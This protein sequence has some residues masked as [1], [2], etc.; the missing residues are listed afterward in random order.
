MLAVPWL[1][2]FAALF[3]SAQYQYRK[4]IRDDA[5]EQG[6]ETVITAVLS[7]MKC[8]TAAANLVWS[9]SFSVAC[10]I[11]LHCFWTIV[12]PAYRAF[13]AAY[14]RARWLTTWTCVCLSVHWVFLLAASFVELPSR[15][16]SELGSTDIFRTKHEWMN[17]DID[18]PI[19][20]D[21]NCTYMERRIRDLVGKDCRT[22]WDETHLGAPVLP[23]HMRLHIFSALGAFLFF[24]LA[25]LGPLKIYLSAPHRLPCKMR[26]GA[27]ILWMVF[28]WAS[29]FVKIPL[30]GALHAKRQATANVD[31]A[32]QYPLFAG[33]LLW[34]ASFALDDAV[35]SEA[36]R[37]SDAKEGGAVPALAVA[38]SGEAND[39]PL[40]AA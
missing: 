26:W 16:C 31:G 10:V 1:L 22:D 12:R 37:R 29:P 2:L 27:Q 24:Q 4:N 13:F 7:L 28:L 35:L 15:H 25:M 33:M 6:E 21:D 19:N 30:R 17:C 18:V 9:C 3:V 34:Y 14:A 20:E 36:M 38:D 11:T 23:W 32:M 8:D 40:Q 5:Q 39:P